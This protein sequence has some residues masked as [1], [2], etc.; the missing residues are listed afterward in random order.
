[1][2]NNLILDF[3]TFGQDITQC[4]VINCA[5]F[6]FD[7]DRFLSDKPYQF[8]ELVRDIKLLK[9]NVEQQK[10]MYGYTITKDSLAFW[11][12]MPSDVKKQIIPTPN[13]ISVV[14]FCETVIDYIRDKK[15][16]YWWS[17]SN[18]FDPPILH[19]LFR[20]A[21]MEP[22]LL[23]HLKYWMVRDLRTYYDAKF[24]FKAKTNAFIPIDDADE[25]NAI[26]KKHNSIHDVAAE[27]LRLQK[28]SRI[29]HG[30]E[31]G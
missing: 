24:N 14:N 27:V 28:I 12:D 9:L 31:D 20:S 4:A 15:I 19:R 1:M 7:W 13:D 16:T 25:W 29:E 23:E 26:F 21:N 17:R 30:V 8:N 18:T 3:E 5:L 10:K 6:V 11:A 22:L 2:N